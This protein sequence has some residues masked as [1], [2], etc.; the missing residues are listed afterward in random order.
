M[1]NSIYI[2]LSKQ[3]VQFR[4]LNTVAN[5]IANANTT[6][7]K[8]NDFMLTDW[9]VPNGNGQ[10]IS[11]AQ[12][13]RMYRD[14]QDGAL[15]QTNRML[16][17]AIQGDAFLQVETA[18]GPAYTRAGSLQIDPT[19]RLVTDSGAPLL[20]LGGQNILIPEDAREITFAEDG[21]IIV[22]GDE[23][24]RMNVVTFANQQNLQRLSATIYATDDPPLNANVTEFK[25]AQGFLERSN[26]QSIVELTKMIETSRRV[27]STSQFMDTAYDLQRRAMDAWAQ[28]SNR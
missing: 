4:N 27:S 9:T 6:S 7:Y 18:N 23:L 22:D 15:E 21:L 28:Q 11:F 5:N 3:L 19:G 2:A 10:K 8:R 13:L 14:I 17:I 26:V 25:I 1:D 12:D 16:D 20:Q 24:A